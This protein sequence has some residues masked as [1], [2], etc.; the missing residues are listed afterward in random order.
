MKLDEALKRL[1]EG[2]FLNES[3]KFMNNFYPTVK[4]TFINYVGTL[5]EW[6]GQAKVHVV[7]TKVGGW[8]KIPNVCN[9][10]FDRKFPAN[11]IPNFPPNFININ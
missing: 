9:S 6:V 11:F 8:V 5:G 1:N 7:F 3:L 2:S 4:G 10:K